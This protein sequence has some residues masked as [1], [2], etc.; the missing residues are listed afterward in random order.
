VH[1]IWPTAVPIGT[2]KTFDGWSISLLGIAFLFFFAC[3]KLELCISRLLLH[4]AGKIWP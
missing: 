1:W 3:I 4:Y 2:W